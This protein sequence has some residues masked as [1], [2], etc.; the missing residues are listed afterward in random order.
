MPKIIFTC[1]ECGFDNPEDSKVCNKCGIKLYI[2]E[3][4]FFT[5][6]EVF[7]YVKRWICSRCGG[8]NIYGN[9]KCHGCSSNS[10]SQWFDLH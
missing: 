2:Y 4:G 8:K 5:S 10:S 3:S 6:T 9:V 1:K 7:N